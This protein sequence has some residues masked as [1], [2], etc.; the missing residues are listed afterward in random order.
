MYKLNTYGYSIKL[1]CY[2]HYLLWEMFDCEK[3]I[4]KFILRKKKLNET[5]QLDVMY[6]V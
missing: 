2:K 5:K 1:S 3:F 4:I 6:S